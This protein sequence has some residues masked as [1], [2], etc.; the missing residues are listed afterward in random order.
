MHRTEYYCNQIGHEPFADRQAF[1]DHMR[2]HHDISFGQV[3]AQE[4]LSMFSRPKTSHKGVCPLCGIEAKKLENHLARHMERLALFALPRDNGIREEAK[5]DNFDISVNLVLGSEDSTSQIDSSSK[6]D[7]NSNSGLRSTSYTEDDAEVGAGP[8]QQSSS[9][10]VHIPETHSSA[11]ATSAEE[12]AVMEDQV[13]VPDAVPVDWDFATTKFR[14]ARSIK[15]NLPLELKNDGWRGST[16]DTME[17][18]HTRTAQSSSDSIKD[19]RDEK[20]AREEPEAEPDLTTP[21]LI[22]TIDN[23]SV[24]FDLAGVLVAEY[25]VGRENELSMMQEVFQ[26]DMS[27]RRTIELQGPGGIGKTQLAVAYAKQHRNEYSAIFWLDSKDKDT[28]LL[29]LQI[30]LRYARL[31]LAPQHI[32]RP[33]HS[34]HN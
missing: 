7:S 14:D 11:A 1:C 23:Y 16:R 33:F 5:E 15:Q 12:R 13:T 24:P 32:V 28:L 3:H 20:F 31:G 26:A 17:E 2:I 8:G 27:R 34:H 30:T 21:A 18:L 10:K 6:K 4:L 29:R 19:V 9:R 22:S 25:F